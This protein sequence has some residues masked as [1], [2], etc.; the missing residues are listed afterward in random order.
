[1]PFYEMIL[2]AL[3]SIVKFKVIDNNNTGQKLIGWPWA[4]AAIQRKEKPQESLY[5]ASEVI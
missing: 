3:T 1:M 5:C 2:L 4:L